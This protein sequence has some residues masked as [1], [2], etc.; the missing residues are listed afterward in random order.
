MFVTVSYRAWD[1]LV[2][3]GLLASPGSFCVLLNAGAKHTAEFA[4]FNVGAGDGT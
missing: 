1:L 4:A 2:K 3:L